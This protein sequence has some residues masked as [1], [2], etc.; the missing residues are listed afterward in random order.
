[1]AFFSFKQAFSWTTAITFLSLAVSTNASLSGNESTSPPKAITANASYDEIMFQ[2]VLDFDQDG[3]YNVPAIDQKGNVDKGLGDPEQPSFTERLTYSNCRNASDLDNNQVYSRGRCNN[4]WCV[5]IYDYYFER[6]LDWFIN[7]RYEW[8]HIAVWIAKNKTQSVSVTYDGKWETRN[9]TDVIFQGPSP[10]IVYHRKKI[11]THGF[12]FDF[13]GKNKTIE[14]HTGKWFK[15]PLLSYGGWPREALRDKLM[16]WS[17]LSPE[18]L[19]TPE[20]KLQKIA[21]KDGEFEWHINQTKPWDFVF[22]EK[23]HVNNETLYLLPE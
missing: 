2:P 13:H 18:W 22:D 20:R 6:D 5:I 1:M 16:N 23:V 19:W 12:R 17:W 7:L 8:E 3:C 11:N 14:N 10:K 21:I 9:S 4:G 15:G